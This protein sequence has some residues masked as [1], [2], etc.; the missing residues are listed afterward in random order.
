MTAESIRQIAV[1]RL[2]EKIVEGQTKMRQLRYRPANSVVAT[3]GVA[4]MAANSAEEIGMLACELNAEIAALSA[5]IEIINE[6]YRT[7]TSPKT[8][9]ELEG[10]QE[11][12]Q[13]KFY[14]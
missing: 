14:G 4:V 7:I 5:A 10:K 11:Q 1:Q 8:P 12:K 3:T 6:T 13:E 2:Q 9:E